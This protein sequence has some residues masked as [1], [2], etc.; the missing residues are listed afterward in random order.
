MSRVEVRYFY[1][2]DCALCEAMENQLGALMER[3]GLENQ[4]MIISCD[5]E[6]DSKWYD[7]YREYVP[8]LVV[9]GQEVCHYFLDEQELLDAISAVQDRE[10]GRD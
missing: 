6:N 10:A 5:I 7:L 9:D 8:V 3:H 4:V 1:K 2:L